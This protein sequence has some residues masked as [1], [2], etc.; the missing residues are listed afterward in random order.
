LLFTWLQAA[1]SKKCSEDSR[2]AVGS[3]WSFI[4]NSSG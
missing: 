4:P 1:C 2:N 3:Y